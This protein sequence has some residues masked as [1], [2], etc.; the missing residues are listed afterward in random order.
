MY[1]R[2]PNEEW[3]RRSGLSGCASLAEL[4]RGS[5]RVA[6]QDRQSGSQASSQEILELAAVRRGKERLYARRGRTGRRELIGRIND[7]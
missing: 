5:S 1:M 7:P 6:Q 4:L 3:R 2:Q